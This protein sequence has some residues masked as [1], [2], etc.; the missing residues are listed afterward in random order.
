MDPVQKLYRVLL[1]LIVAGLV[2]YVAFLNPVL[3]IALLVGV[4][5]AMFLHQVLG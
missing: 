1:I 2:T 3:G 4:G 5:V